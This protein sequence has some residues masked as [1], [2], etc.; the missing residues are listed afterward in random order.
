MGTAN[1]T[2]NNLGEMKMIKT[3]WISPD[4]YHGQDLLVFGRCLRCGKL[5]T[6]TKKFKG[7]EYK[8]CDITCDFIIERWI[9]E[10]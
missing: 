7:Y 1:V 10:K 6:K 5:A 2:S 3:K 8:Y 4:D 9:E